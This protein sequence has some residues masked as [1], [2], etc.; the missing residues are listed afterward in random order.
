MGRG[1][2]GVS[3]NNELFGCFSEVRYQ[4]RD[5]TLGDVVLCGGVKDFVELELARA[6]GGRWPHKSERYLCFT[7]VRVLVCF[8]LG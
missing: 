2:D 4:V 1:A 5:V 6:A 8:F 7:Y 3:F